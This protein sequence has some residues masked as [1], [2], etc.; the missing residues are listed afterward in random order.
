MPSR[1]SSAGRCILVVLLVGF[2]FGLAVPAVRAQDETAP[3]ADQPQTGKKAEDLGTFGWIAH[4]TLVGWMVFITIIGLSIMLVAMIV[5]LLLDLRGGNM[6]PGDFVEAFEDAM[7]KRKFKEAFE[8]AKSDP[9]LLGRVLTAGMTRLQHGLPEAREASASMID[10]LKTRKD[11]VIAYMATIGTL[12]PLFGLVGTVS[13]MIT[14]F[15]VLGRGG[16]PS[17]AD[18]ASGISEALWMTLLGIS[19]ALPAIFFYSFFRNRMARIAIDANLLA[20]D[21]L[22]QMFHSS[23]GTAAAPTKSVP[24][25][26][27]TAPM[28]GKSA[29]EV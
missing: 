21:M 11:H 10:S 5:W 8:L 20:D 26:S 14:A 28:A 2:A 19:L 6:M 9:S 13:G 18:L 15:G 12:G 27:A 1:A 24:P 16:N 7:S 22:T 17:A 23:R 4:L 3:A 29:P 25:G